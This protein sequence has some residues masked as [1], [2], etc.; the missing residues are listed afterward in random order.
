MND[1]ERW[2]RV[3]AREALRS[4]VGAIQGAGDLDKL[5]VAQ[6]Q[7]LARQIRLSVDFI[8]EQLEGEND[9]GN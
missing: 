7:V 2:L 8:D 6:L 4:I 1:K 5:D 3:E 9:D